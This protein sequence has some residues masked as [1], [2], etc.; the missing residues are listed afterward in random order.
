MQYLA[1]G[2]TT[3]SSGGGSTG[4]EG[5]LNVYRFVGN[6]GVNLIDPIGWAS[7]PDD[8]WPSLINVSSEWNKWDVTMRFSDGNPL[9]TYIKKLE[10][11]DHEIK[12][13]FS[14]C[15][16]LGVWITVEPSELYPEKDWTYSRIEGWDKENN[17]YIYGV[18]YNPRYVLIVNSSET[19]RSLA[20]YNSLPVS[21][22]HGGSLLWQMTS[23]KYSA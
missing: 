18:G 12:Y 20:N 7:F 14:C 5:G 8:Q 15:T 2:I 6:G 13:D 19:R 17:K 10:G 11:S 4:I 3:P 23:K 1:T 16:I 9:R 22:G 21:S